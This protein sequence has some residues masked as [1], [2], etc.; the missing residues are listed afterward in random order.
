[1]KQHKKRIVIVGLAV[2]LAS[3]AGVLAA[4]QMQLGASPFAQIQM[5]TNLLSGEQSLVSPSN[6]S[7]TSESATEHYAEQNFSVDEHEE[8][9]YTIDPVLWNL[10]QQ[11]SEGDRFL[12]ELNGVVLPKRCA[13]RTLY[14][15]CA[16]ERENRYTVISGMFPNW[17]SYA[18]PLSEWEALGGFDAN[19]LDRLKANGMPVTA[20][21]EA[22]YDRAVNRLEERSRSHKQAIFGDLEAFV[23]EGIDGTLDELLTERDAYVWYYWSDVHYQIFVSLTASEIKAFSVANCFNGMGEYASIRLASEEVMEVV[24]SH[25]PFPFRETF[26]IVR[27]RDRYED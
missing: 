8:C 27:Y 6:E 16:T 2:L 13:D 11:S 17:L 15:T 23:V 5:Q 12:V 9:P 25:V 7:D 24:T 22:A 19:A 10:M 26:G 3:S 14:E 20:E 1:M 4:C 18:N 21:Q